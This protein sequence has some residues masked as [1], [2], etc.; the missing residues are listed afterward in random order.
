VGTGT[1]DFAWQC[2]DNQT[3]REQSYSRR[4]SRAG[5]TSTTY[6]NWCTAAYLHIYGTF[7]Y[8]VS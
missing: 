8:R 3:N 4:I 2:H 5:S 7:V 6:K 1:W